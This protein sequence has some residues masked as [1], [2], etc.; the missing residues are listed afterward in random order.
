MLSNSPKSG[1]PITYSY[2]AAGTRE[3]QAWLRQAAQDAIAGQ[4]PLDC[5]V[6]L[7]L[8][9]CMP[10]FSSGMRKADR[11]LAERELLPHAKRPDT[12]NLLKAIED[13]F[14][15]VIWS[16]DARVAEHR[17]SSTSPRPRLVVEVRPI[18]TEGL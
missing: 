3:Y 12:C 11:L 13:A 16:D 1:R 15:A 7:T 4:P 8:T 5:P 18:S 14:K 9:A 17:L 6:V 10:I 2:K